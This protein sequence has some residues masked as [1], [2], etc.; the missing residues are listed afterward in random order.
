MAVEADGVHIGQS[1]LPTQI[2]RQLIDQDKILGVSVSTLQ[3]ALEAEKHGAD[4]LGV[5]PIYEARGTKSDARIPFGLTL[6][7][8]I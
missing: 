6:I 8:E 3:E 1:D 5:G 4:Y 7:S 2:T